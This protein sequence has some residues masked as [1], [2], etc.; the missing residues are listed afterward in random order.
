MSAMTELVDNL[1]V[2]TDTLLKWEKAV[3]SIYDEPYVT[4]VNEV[5]YRYRKL[6]NGS[7]LHEISPTKDALRFHIHRANY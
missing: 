4:S 7:E 6:P 3:C 2:S 5:I 1:E